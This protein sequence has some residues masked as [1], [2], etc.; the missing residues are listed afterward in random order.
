VEAEGGG[1]RKGGDK[2]EKDVEEMVERGRVEGGRR[3][4]IRQ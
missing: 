3:G 2:E 1:G 4:T